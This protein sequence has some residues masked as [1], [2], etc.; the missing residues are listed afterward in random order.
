[1]DGCAHFAFVEQCW[2]WQLSSYRS[3]ESDGDSSVVEVALVV[4]IGTNSIDDDE[5][6]AT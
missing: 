4:A 5:G 6:M 3:G 2:R 1:M